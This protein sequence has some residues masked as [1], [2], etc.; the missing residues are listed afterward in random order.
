MTLKPTIRAV[1]VYIVMALCLTGP[2]GSNLCAQE[3]EKKEEKKGEEDEKKAKKSLKEI[4]SLKN[5][6][7]KN[8]ST[9][10]A[11]RYIRW[12]KRLT[13]GDKDY[14]FTI[15]KDDLSELFPFIRKNTHPLSREVF[16]WYPYW[17]EDLYKYLDYSL[18]STVA[19]FSYKVDHKTGKAD[20]TKVNTLKQWNEPG[21]IEA[22]QKYNDSNFTDKKILL[23]VSLFGNDEMK[24]FLKNQKAWDTLFNNVVT[25]LDAKKANG[26]CLDLESVVN[27]QRNNYNKFVASFS[28]QLKAHNEEYLVYLTVPAVDWNESLQY[29]ILIPAIDRFVIMGYNYYGSTSRQAGP[30][31]PLESGKIWR[32]FNLTTSVDQ[33]LVNGVPNSKLI[34][35]LPFYGSIWQTKTGR[36]GSKADRF[37]G[38]RTID[39]IKTVMDK[40]SSI[41]MQYDSASHTSWYSYPEKDTIKNR[42]QFRQLWFDSDSAFAEKLN[43]IKEK[44]IAGMGIWALGYNKRCD[45]YWREIER[46]FCVPGDT[47]FD[48]PIELKDLD[49]I[50]VIFKGANG[51][52]DSTLVA[53]STNKAKKEEEEQEEEAAGVTFLDTLK[54]I[55]EKLKEIS[56]LDDLIMFVIG[57]VVLFGG[58]GL[59]ISM[60]KP[61]TRMFFFNSKAYTVYFTIILSV[62]FVVLMRMIDAIKD[63]TVIL[64]FGFV[65]GAIMVYLV[66]RYVQKVKRNLP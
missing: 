24:S 46:S 51:L 15:A 57:F 17:D 10:L 42:T 59:I 22:I 54:G 27:S 14:R 61:N 58:I 53:D 34:L 29:D 65:V 37:I 1:F 26:V 30:V 11:K 49:S 12:H 6:L 56:G 60:F 4:L 47:V 3:D 13:R 25:L 44:D 8:D 36:K 18:L 20:T 9:R 41:T 64:L 32:P 40:E 31:A 48:T 63:P 62:F 38:S 39:Y 5:L 21:I 16:G 55:N 45:N 50:I 28:Q 7:H 19:Y 2:M 23:T 52:S 43:F 35:A 66:S 33:Y